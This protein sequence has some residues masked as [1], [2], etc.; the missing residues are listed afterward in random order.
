MKKILLIVF[1]S[2]AVSTFTAGYADAKLTRDERKALRIQR[3]MN[4]QLDKHSDHM[5]KWQNLNN[6]ASEHVRNQTKLEDELWEK[7]HGRPRW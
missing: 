5:K 2:F 6:E 1:L 4:R 3:R 7:Q